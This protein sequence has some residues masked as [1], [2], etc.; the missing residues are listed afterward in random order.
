[1]ET[2]CSSPHY[3]AAITWLLILTNFSVPASTDRF[4]S[5]YQINRNDLNKGKYVRT[6]D[7]ARNI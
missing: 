4:H 6:D 1:M 5:L 2:F 7:N 3:A